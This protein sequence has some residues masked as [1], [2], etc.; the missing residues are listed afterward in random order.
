MIAGPNGS[1]KST[2]IET[3][4]PMIPL[5]VY[6]NADEIESSLKRKPLL[7]FEDFSLNTSQKEF[8]SFI[9]KKTTIGTLSFKE[10]LISKSSIASNI[11]VVDA[12][13]IDSYLASL[14]ADFIRVQLLKQDKSFSFETVMSHS[15]K[16]QFV[17]AA[18][19]KSYQ[20]YLYFVA[21]NSPLI[22]YGRIESRVIKGGHYVSEQKT[23]ER[24]NRSLG[25]LNAAIKKSYRSFI[26]DNSVSLTLMAEYKE[27]VLIKQHAPFATWFLNLD[28]V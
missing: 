23:T 20:T 11:L 27:G 18:N 17:S 28:I 12:I 10:E 26:F 19:K 13:L 15:S 14:I 1:G 7:H 3:L 5:G 16:V 6:I 25:L 9:N 21:T 24:Y 22:N 2:L 4:Q 8:H